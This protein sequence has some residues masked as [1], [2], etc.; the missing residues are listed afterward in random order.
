MHTGLVDRVG[1]RVNN[2]YKTVIERLLPKIERMAKRWRQK[3]PSASLG[4]FEQAG[5]HAVIK[6]LDGGLKYDPSIGKLETCFHQQIDGAMK[7]LVRKEV[8]SHRFE[9]EA[10]NA[11]KDSLSRQAITNGNALAQTWMEMVE[12]E[13]VHGYAH[14][15]PEEAVMARESA[16]DLEAFFAGLEETDR[17]LVR[18]DYV[19]ERPRAE[20]VALLGFSLA[21]LHRKKEKIR[22]RLQEHL[23]NSR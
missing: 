23:D 5:A 10:A 19:E 8:T 21:T 18:L 4:D 1:A 13:A 14:Q 22:A 15:T 7:M 3:C 11:V 20:I 6:A 16:A 9:R 12:V 17:E 2:E